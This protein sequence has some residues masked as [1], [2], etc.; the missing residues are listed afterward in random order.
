MAVVLVVGVEHQVVVVVVGVEHQVLVLVLVGQLGPG[1]RHHRC[2]VKE[3]KVVLIQWRLLS[4]NIKHFI[5]PIAIDLY[6][7][8]L[9]G[10]LIFTEATLLK[11]WE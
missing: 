4:H 6:N 3:G 8:T 1:H 10:S 5:L 11:M 9:F 7:R 2:P